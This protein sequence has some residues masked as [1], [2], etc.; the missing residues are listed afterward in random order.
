MSLAQ[1]V[2]EAWAIV[3]PSAPLVW[4]WHLGALT[5]HIAAL[6][7]GTLGRQNLLV[8]IPPG[9]GKSLVTSVCAP[10]W[11]WINRP[12]WS[13]IFASTTPVV[14]ERDAVRRKLLL[15]SAWYR[16]RFGIAWRL[17]ETQNTKLVY[18]NTSGGTHVAVSTGSRI[19]G[20]RADALFVDD[21][22]D[23][24]DAHSESARQSVVMWWNLA[25]ANRLKDLRRG[26]RLIIMQ[27]LH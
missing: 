22:L 2:R 13:A 18:G 9:S 10:C 11:Q 24:A 26:T 7:T 12:E 15:E 19:I 6:L 8:T 17:S 5:E 1:F 23:P 25:F 21:P 4:N 3:E 16:Q 20:A 14:T 27:R